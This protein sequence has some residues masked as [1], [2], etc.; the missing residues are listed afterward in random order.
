MSIYSI[1][2]IK[3]VCL[4][5]L[6]NNLKCTVTKKLLS[7]QSPLTSFCV[8]YLPEWLSLQTFFY[9]LYFFLCCET[10]IN[11]T[12]LWLFQTVTL[13]TLEY[14]FTFQTFHAD[15]TD[16]SSCRF[17]ERST[18]LFYS[19]T[20]CSLQEGRLFQ[21]SYSD[22]DKDEVNDSREAK[23]CLNVPTDYTLPPWQLSM[24]AQCVTYNKANCISA[25][26]LTATQDT[27]LSVA[28]PRRP[29]PAEGLKRTSRAKVSD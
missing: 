16:S 8:I 7:V 18:C 12:Y 10:K 20:I 26:T 6:P 3:Y 9:C 19:Q 24:G 13:E 23:A 1:W 17:P 21:G 15:R 2:L 5:L 4:I 22:D 28:A 11:E 25:L 27:L 14:V 29:D